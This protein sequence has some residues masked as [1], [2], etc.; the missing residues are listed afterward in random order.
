MTQVQSQKVQTAMGEQEVDRTGSPVAVVR[1]DVGES[2]GGVGEL[3][4]SHIND[5]SEQAWRKI[6]AK[7]DYTYRCLDLALFPL[8]KETGFVELIR[9][10]LEKGQNLLFKPNLVAMQ[11]IDPQTH[12]PGPL[13]T[14][15]TEWPFVAALMRWFHDKLGVSY[16]RMAL[17]EA[18]TVMPAV[19]RLYCLLHPRGT[20][21]TVEAAVEGR[22]VDFYGGWGFYF[23]RRYL[24]DSLGPHDAEDPM[25]GFEESVGGIYLPPG[26]AGD[27]LMVY[28]LNR[29]SDDPTKGREVKVAGGINYGAITLHKAVVG[30]NPNSRADREAYP[31]CVL[32]NVPKLKVHSIT[33]FTNVIKNLGIGLYPM[34]FA[35]RGGCRWDYG[36]PHTD[37]P[38]MKGAIPHEVW[39]P[40]LDMAT[41]LPKTDA[42]GNY[43]VKKTGGINATMCDIIKAVSGLD[44]PML[45]VVD[46]IE[47][48]NYDH[49]GSVAAERTPEGLVFAGTDPVATDLL[50]ARY[51]FGNVPLKEAME[52]G[53][54][55]GMGGRF[56]QSVPV[57]A[58]EGRHIV[59]RKGCDCPLSRDRSFQEAER[60]GLGTRKYHVVGHDTVA[61]APVVSVHGHLGTVKGGVFSDLTTST[62]Y[63]DIFKLPWD[64]QRTALSYL[65]AVDVR[66]ASSLKMQFLEA[67]DE[68]GDGIVTYDEFGRR[69]AWGS[70]IL[71][72]GDGVSRMGAEPLG[73]LKAA[74][75]RVA[76]LKYADPALNPEG[77]D[78]YRDRI[79]GAVVLT[80][81]RISQLD[82]E[83]PDPFVEGA[84]CGR[85]RW[86]SYALARHFQT[87]GFLYG[88]GFPHG[89]DFPSIYAAALL[90]A[91][92]TQNGGRYAGP[93]RTQPDVAAMNRYVAGALKGEEPLLDFTFYVPTGFERLGANPIPNVEATT[94]P[95]KILTAR[96]AGGSETW[97]EPLLA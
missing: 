41:G 25:R 42:V 91:D 73:Y 1:L 16:Y 12:G 74:F 8:D 46:A 26:K 37:I 85:G 87:G 58:L 10:R 96:F 63:F 18:A 6:R 86:P 4:Q 50:C 93:V 3:L 39:V 24:A 23:V 20:R 21:V 33:L 71:L 77:H 88:A 2:Y 59:T 31:G 51:I 17:G 57:A 90:Y 92:L 36:V 48:I 11:N 64:M 53:L 67:F 89:V 40:E 56:A 35:A 84:S 69:G 28:D 70:F 29:L 14:T 49:M 60:R 52:S 79:L 78:I 5:G 45:H 43:L 30:G 38:G 94:D 7:I 22:C 95:S 66:D 9:T 82:M 97:P 68:D 62:L 47:A 32:I 80:A 75:N 54:E 83:F 15:C 13:G 34:Q 27:R 81:Y 61:D 19:A 76:M 55:D 72:A 65:E 44:T